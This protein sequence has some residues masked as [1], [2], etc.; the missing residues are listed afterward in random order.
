MLAP[1]HLNEWPTWPELMAD[2]AGIRNQDWFRIEAAAGSRVIVQTMNLTGGADTIVEIYD[3]AGMLLLATDDN[4]GD[5]QASYL[6]WQPQASDTYHIRVVAAP[7][8][9]YGCNVGYDLAVTQNIA[10]FLPL[11]VRE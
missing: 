7:T 11:I 1:L 8:S 6:E 2:I 4:S 3:A 5:G 10:L 9:A